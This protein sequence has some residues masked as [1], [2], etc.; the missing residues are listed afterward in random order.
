M[1]RL[2]H[3]T[4]SFPDGDRRI[5]AVDDV[6]L[7]VDRG[8]VVGITGPSGSG[9]SSLLAVASTLISPDAGT[10][11]VDDVDAT[12]LSL[13]ERA[14]LRRD[15]IGIVFQQ[16]N[17]IPSLTAEEQ[18][19]VMGELDGPRRG[20]SARNAARARARELLDA[21]GLADNA[22]K[23]PAQLS[24]GQR[25]RVNI[26]RALMNEPSALVVDEPTSALD[27]ERGS[28]I[29]ALILRLTAEFDTATILVTHDQRLLPLMT[30]VHSMVDG[31]LTTR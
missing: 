18:L 12:A 6:S 21:V 29:L 26:A 24:G 5:T 28:S 1:I 7:T 4:L 16:S 19:V 8:S 14:E 2:D 23:H 13:A 20:R 30:S 3:I 25:Q 11:H 9:K 22:A 17:L 10:L 27:Q 31:A 15:S